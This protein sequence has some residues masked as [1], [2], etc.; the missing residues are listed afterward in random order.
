M[1][2]GVVTCPDGSGYMSRWEWLHVQVG[3]VTCPG[4]RGYV[5]VCDFESQRSRV[6]I[7][8]VIWFLISYTVFNIHVSACMGH[9]CERAVVL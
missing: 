7:W 6:Q 3:V 1:Q 5:Y 4:E 8:I 2:V 9:V